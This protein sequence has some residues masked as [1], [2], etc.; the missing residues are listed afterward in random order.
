M[1][2]D[3]SMQSKRRVLTRKALQMRSTFDL[4]TVL[5]QYEL[6]GEERQLLREQMRLIKSS[7]RSRMSLDSL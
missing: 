2:R 3:K 4:L 5:L 6:T 7:L 1:M